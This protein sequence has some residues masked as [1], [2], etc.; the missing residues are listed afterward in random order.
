MTSKEFLERSE[1]KAEIFRI[2]AEGETDPTLRKIY[3]ERRQR[4]IDGPIYFLSKICRA[5]RRYETCAFTRK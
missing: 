5:N 4:L 3:K 1:K 2:L